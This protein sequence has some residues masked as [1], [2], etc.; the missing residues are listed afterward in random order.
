MMDDRRQYKLSHKQIAIATGTPVEVV[1]PA[2]SR[3]HRIALEDPVVDWRF[4]TESAG[5]ADGFPQIGGSVLEIDGPVLK[6]SVW[7]YQASGGSV[8]LHWHYEYPN[9]R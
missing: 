8:D 2:G 7:V 3:N 6:M 4:S 1:L 5:A 9:Y